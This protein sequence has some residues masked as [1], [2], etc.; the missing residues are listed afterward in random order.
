MRPERVASLTSF[1][2]DA[3][4]LMA[5]LS[6]LVDPATGIV[7]SLAQVHYPWP[8][9][10]RFCVFEARRPRRAQE[11]GGRVAIQTE[12]GRGFGRDEARA[13]ALFEA[14][15]RHCLARYSTETFEYGPFEELTRTGREAIDPRAFASNERADEGRLLECRL[16]WTEA[17]AFASGR[18][19]LVPA[20]QVFLP[21][22]FE[23]GE[24]VL[25]D[26]LTTGAAAG[27]ARGP[28]TLRGLLEVIERDAAMIVHYR[29]L[30]CS[31]IEVMG[32]EGGS[33][34][35][36]VAHISDLGLD[37][38]LYDYSIDWAIPI[39]ACV[40]RDPSGAGLPLSVGSKAALDVF[41]AAK[42]A[43]LE[44]ACYRPAIRGLL[45]EARER[46]IPFMNR[47]N[48]IRSGELRSYIWAQPEMSG[49]LGYLDAGGET[50]PI[51][52]IPDGEV[53]TLIDRVL[54][55]SSGIYVADVATPDIEAFGIAVVKVIVPG[56]QHMHLNERDRVWT[57]RILSF[58]ARESSPHELNAV[59]HPFL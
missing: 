46:A 40:I 53:G 57:E 42:G 12:G 8:D 41:S 30:A 33:L 6:D 22:R 50:T 48:E 36:A 23:E 5:V 35:A 13:A 2:A 44:A 4:R 24:P 51:G 7:R 45:P 19:C 31:R 20:Q 18:P 27:L 37:V 26:P 52:E 28:A 55:R 1:E 54:E 59:P 11:S 38:A 58:G 9:E 43:L 34:A 21:Y 32:S 49:E 3:S 29:R 14:I 39:V 15:E 47:P 17:Q 10:P 16:P 25:R 56:L